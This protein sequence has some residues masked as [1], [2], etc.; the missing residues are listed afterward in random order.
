MDYQLYTLPSGLH[1]VHKP[2]AGEVTYA[3][4]AIAVGTRHESSRHHGLAHLTEHMLFKGTSLRNSLQIIRRMEEVGAELN[5]FT[6]KESTYVYCIFPKAH[7]NRASNLLF[8]IVQHSRFP[9]EELTK[10]KTVIIDEINS[11]RDNPSELIFDEFENI[12][13][14]HHPLGHNILGTEASVSRITGQ[15]GRNFL[16]R[17]YRP[18]NMIFF[19]AGEAD[20]SDWPLNPA[21]KVS[22]HNTDGTPLHTLRDGFL[23]RTI[24]RHKDTYQHHILMGGPAYS[25]HDD[26]RI[27]LSLLNNILGGP[28]MNS[29][30]NL[31]LREEH[32]YVYNVESNYTPYSDTGIFNIYLGCAPRHAE[33]AMELVRKELR[34]LIEHPL[35]PIELES[36]KRQFKGQLIVSADNKE[37]TFLSLGKSMLLYGKYDPLSVIFSRIDAITS[38]RLREIAAEVLNPDSMLTLIYC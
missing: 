18:D 32:G 27:P 29:R 24:R 28:G 14:R 37:S 6:E 13:F 5:A 36:A 34:Y 30:L 4:F 7:F 21:E 25:L 1:V 17:H 9:E 16:R 19:L 35:S 15:I 3:G 10:E 38:D 11:Y 20:L 33:A 26:R 12:L 22:I 31:S 23:P 2:H 8:D